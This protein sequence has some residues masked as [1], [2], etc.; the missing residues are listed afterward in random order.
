LNERRP[1]Q[2]SFIATHT[3]LFLAVL[4]RIKFENDFAAHQ[5]FLEQQ[6]FEAAK[7]FQS[8]QGFREAN[9]FKA[10]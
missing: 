4:D 3:N 8:E 10:D 7:Q 5:R 9:L 2:K 1:V 6:R